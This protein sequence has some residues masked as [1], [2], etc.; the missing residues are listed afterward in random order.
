[1]REAVQEER[2]NAQGLKVLRA[3][4]ETADMG[5]AIRDYERRRVPFKRA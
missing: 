5:D 3:E 1:V 2:H 4:P